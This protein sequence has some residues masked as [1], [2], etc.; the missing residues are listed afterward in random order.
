MKRYRASGRVL[1]L[2]PAQGRSMVILWARCRGSIRRPEGRPTCMPGWLIIWRPGSGLA[3]W[4]RAPGFLPSATLPRNTASQWAL[5][6]GRLKSYGSGGWRSR[7]RLR[8]RSSAS[9]PPVG[10]SFRPQGDSRTRATFR[11][12]EGAAQVRCRPSASRPDFLSFGDDHTGP[13]APPSRAAHRAS[14]GWWWWARMRRP[15]FSA[16]SGQGT[17]P[18]GSGSLSLSARSPASTRPR[19]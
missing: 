4:P 10:S 17:W 5:R 12:R 16:C 6:G 19:M 9:R 14:Q 1:L 13:A 3:S 2:Y 15:P 7:C 11:F 8:G 18:R